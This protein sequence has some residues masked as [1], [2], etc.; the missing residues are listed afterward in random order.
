MDVDIC[1]INT[2]RNV[3]I[4]TVRFTRHLLKQEVRIGLESGVVGKAYPSEDTWLLVPRNCHCCQEEND[5]L[6]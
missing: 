6:S 5:W 3:T 2:G 4:V 1:K